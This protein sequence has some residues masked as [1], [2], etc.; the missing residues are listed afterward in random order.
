MGSVNTNKNNIGLLNEKVDKLMQ[1]SKMNHLRI[2]GLPEEKE[3]KSIIDN[4]LRFFHT[5][6]DI[7]CGSEEINNI[8]R[9]G[10]LSTEEPRTILV[11]FVQQSKRAEV[12]NSKKYIS[13]FEDLSQQRYNLLKAAKRKLGSKKAWPANGNIYVWEEDKKKRRLVS[14][15]EDL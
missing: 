3:N 5:K 7:I 4:V 1:L 9:L 10:R 8:Y 15:V 12:L 11:N 6:L 14:C 13:I 2:H